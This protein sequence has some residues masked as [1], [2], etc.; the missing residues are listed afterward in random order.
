MEK[1]HHGF[2]AGTTAGCLGKDPP[3][4]GLDTGSAP[5]RGAETYMR[6]A[7]VPGWRARALP[8]TTYARHGL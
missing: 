5:A 2:G 3:K 4:P 8:G 6:A 7:A 1:Y